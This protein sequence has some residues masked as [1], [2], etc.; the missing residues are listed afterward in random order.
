MEPQIPQ[1]IPQTTESALSPSHKPLL[2][3]KD[4]KKVYHS[5]KKNENTALKGISFTVHE[6]EFIALTGQSGSGKSSLLNMLG[7]LDVPT[8]GTLQ[9]NGKDVL[10]LTSK[11]RADLRLEVVSFV[12]QFFNLINNLSALENIMLPLRLQGKSY[13]DA[14]N[15]GMKTLTSLGLS[16]SANSLAGD[17]SGGEQQRVAIGRALCKES[18]IILADEPTA[19]LD[20]IRS[21]EVMDL[22]LDINRDYRRTIILVTHERAQAAQADRCLVIKDGLIVEDVRRV[23]IISGTLT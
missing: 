11:G 9:I 4:V 15:V 6:G 18:A 5:G 22:L 20:S 21:Q 10:S 13:D 23:P 19:H 3:L 2:E 8:S 1:T 7:L 14:Y 17:L 12:F 16:Q